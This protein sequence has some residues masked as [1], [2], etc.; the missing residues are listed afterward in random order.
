MNDARYYLQQ[1]WSESKLFRYLLGITVVYALLRLLLQAVLLVGLLW[2][3]PEYDFPVIPVDLQVY[4]DASARLAARQDLYLQGP[5]TRLEE[6]Y[7][8][9]PSFALAFTP[10]YRLYRRSP[11]AVSF[12]HTALHMLA[13]GLLYLRW[14][15]IFKRLKLTAANRMLARTLPLWL[16]YSA[17]WDDLLYLNVY[18][19]T[20]LLATL[21]IEALLAARLGRSVGWL[22]VILQIKPFWA[23]AAAALPPAKQFK[24]FL[25]LVLW[26]AVGY[27]AVAGITAL[28]V[29]PRYGW[30]QHADYVAFLLRLSREFPWRGPEAP[31]LGYN[32]SIKQILFYGLGVTPGAALLATGVK[33]LLLAPLAMVYLRRLTH[34]ADEQT[35]RRVLEF[36]LALYLGAFIWLDMVW[37]LTLSIAIFPYLLATCRHR[38]ARALMCALFL[39]YALLDAWRLVSVAIFGTGVIL[40]GLYLTT[41]PNIYAP[42]IMALN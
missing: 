19:I 16:V 3:G 22:V 33:G 17:F 6:L 21:L 28:A 26:G 32:H 29:G 38:G 35:P 2:Y 23:F 37:E 34:P 41:D 31:F 14:V 27:V 40:P 11:G 4:V 25:R 1:V 9:T 36:A 15:A 18:I 12:I 24:F 30:Q 5:I 39:P 42:L 7:Q 10:F 20:A 8:Y 13:Y